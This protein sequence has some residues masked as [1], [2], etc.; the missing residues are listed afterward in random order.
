MAPGPAVGSPGGRVK[1][2]RY[3]PRVCNTNCASISRHL[4]KT[5]ELSCCLDWLLHQ[6]GMHLSRPRRLPAG[7]YGWLQTDATLAEKLPRTLSV[8]VSTRLI[9]SCLNIDDLERRW[10]AWYPGVTR[11][12]LSPFPMRVL[13]SSPAILVRTRKRQ[14]CPPLD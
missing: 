1:L 9:S 12:Q 8:R 10:T 5:Q 13:K 7:K 4:A 3:I 14:A 11:Y 6:P 2:R